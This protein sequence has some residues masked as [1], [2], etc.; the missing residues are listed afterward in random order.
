MPQDYAEAA[1]C[2]RKAADG[3][4]AEAQYNLGV[5]YEKGLGVSRGRDSAMRWYRLA[6]E[7][8]VAE[9]QFNLAALSPPGDAA[10]VSWFRLAAER[11]LAAAQFNLALRYRDGDGVT[12][13]NAAAYFWLTL[14]AATQYPNAEAV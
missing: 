8:G 10:A 1:R 12:A 11:G 9:A 13:D 5:L 14:A 4:L 2:Y 7:R 3:G 6:A